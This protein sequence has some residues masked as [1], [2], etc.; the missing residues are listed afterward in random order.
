VSCGLYGVNKNLTTR[1]YFIHSGLCLIVMNETT[2]YFDS[3]YIIQSLGESDGETG[4]KLFDLMNSES[5]FKNKINFYYCDPFDKTEL[6]EELS[7]IMTKEIKRNGSPAL[8]F[9]AHGNDDGLKLR[10]GSYISWV[11]LN[12]ILVSFNIFSKFNL[13]VTLACCEGITFI[14]TIGLHDRAPVAGLVGC[15]G[16]VY[17][18]ELLAGFSDFYAALLNKKDNVNAVDML[19]NKIGKEATF[20]FFLAE[21]MFVM[22]HKKYLE[23]CNDSLMHKKRMKYLKANAEI[24]AKQSGV[25]KIFTD[26]DVYQ[27]MGGSEDKVFNDFAHRFFMFDKIPSNKNKIN[28]ARLKKLAE[29]MVE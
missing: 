27:V 9:E 20:T 22:V 3:I 7:K 24:R 14:N 17:G 8:H 5:R 11:E 2:Y 13:L 18:D 6:L 26:D 21:R 4:K 10:D 15:E 25:S 12:P 1:S 16:K 23:N 28:V 19:N 29:S